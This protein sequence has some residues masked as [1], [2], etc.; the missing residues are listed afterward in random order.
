VVVR[1]AEG[2]RTAANDP[3]RGL[4]GAGVVR[5]GGTPITRL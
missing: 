4:A 3:A 5:L 1:L 2:M